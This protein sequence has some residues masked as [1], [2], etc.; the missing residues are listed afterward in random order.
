[1]GLNL[2]FK[3]PQ[4]ID[5]SQ[6]SLNLVSGALIHQRANRLAINLL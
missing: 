5:S 3:D 4:E 1:M 6:K 2:N